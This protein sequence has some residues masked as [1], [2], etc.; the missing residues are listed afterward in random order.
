[1][2]MPLDDHLIQINYYSRKFQKR[3]NPI[4]ISITVDLINHILL[5]S[6]DGKVT[7]INI[8]KWSDMS[9]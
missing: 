5:A 7:T 6:V 1:M 8:R 3:S 9:V 2:I 4:Y